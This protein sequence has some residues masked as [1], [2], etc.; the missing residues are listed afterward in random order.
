[1]S[2]SIPKN[3]LN[4]LKKL[5]CIDGKCMREIA[6]Y[7]NVSINAVVYAMRHNKIPRRSLKD[8]NKLTFEHKKPSFCKRKI[9]GIEKVT[10]EIILAMLYWGEGFKG[11]EKSLK[12]D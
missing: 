11:D 4:K 6:L 10:T 9:N 12:N 1:M 5:Y 2:P 7:F 3:K 8:A